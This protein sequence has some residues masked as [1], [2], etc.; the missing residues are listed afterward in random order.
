MLCS[1]QYPRKLLVFI[2]CLR[3][4]FKNNSGLLK[5]VSYHGLNYPGTNSFDYLPLLCGRKQMNW[6][7]IST[8]RCQLQ[9]A[10][11][12]LQD[13]FCQ[14][15]SFTSDFI[16]NQTL[17]EKTAIDRRENSISLNCQLFSLYPFPPQKDPLICNKKNTDWT[18]WSVKK[19]TGSFQA[20]LSH[21]QCKQ[22]I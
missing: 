3:K 5:S 10:L 14:G 15:Q 21:H 13:A 7:R 2:S 12:L 16:A 22:R 18:Q 6:L 19:S 4:C 9:C 11:A 8:S 1:K 17:N 20:R